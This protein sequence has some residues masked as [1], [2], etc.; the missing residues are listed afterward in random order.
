MLIGAV[1]TTLSTAATITL[2]RAALIPLGQFPP[3]YLILTRIDGLSLL[4]EVGT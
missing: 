4:I 1:S 2:S 3:A